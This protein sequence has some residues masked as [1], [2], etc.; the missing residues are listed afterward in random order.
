MDSAHSATAQAVSQL[1]QAKAALVESSKL[2]AHARIVAPFDGVVSERNIN[3]GDLVSPGSAL[4]T[5]VDPSSLRLEAA[6]PA[7]QRAGLREGTPVLFAVTGQ[8]ERI[9]G[10]VER[11]NPVVDPSTGQVRVYVRVPNDS[12]S[13]A[14][15]GGLYAEGRLTTQQAKAPSVPLDALITETDPPEV[16]K[17]NGDQLQRA[18]VKTGIVDPIAEQVQILQGIEPGAQVVTGDVRDLPPGTRVRITHPREATPPEQGVG[19]GGT[20]GTPKD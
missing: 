15:L 3:A 4:F 17:L 18:P 1:E 10:E 6:V 13:T 19:G 2:V 7:D 9:A 11:I 14:L 5:V 16:L 12:G 8:P 20:Q